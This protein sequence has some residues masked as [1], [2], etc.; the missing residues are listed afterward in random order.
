MHYGTGKYGFLPLE[1][2]NINWGKYRT[3]HEQVFDDGILRVFYHRKDQRI[4]QI[5]KPY[6]RE[7][8]ALGNT[9]IRLLTY[10]TEQD[11]LLEDI[12]HKA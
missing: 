5:T 6:H 9:K 12:S 2:K 11:K 7:Q 3:K 1:H 8:S 10:S 4:L